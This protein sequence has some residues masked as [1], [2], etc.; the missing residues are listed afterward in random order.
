MG[1]P[2]RVMDPDVGAENPATMLIKVDLPQPEWPIMQT[3]SPAA[4]SR[5]MFS[6]ATKGPAAVQ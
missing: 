3:N 1:W 4:T 6:K 2:L 5:L